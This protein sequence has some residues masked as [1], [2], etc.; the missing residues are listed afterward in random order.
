[1][2]SVNAG[3]NAWMLAATVLGLLMTAPGLALFYGGLVRRKN[4]LGTMMQSFA[5]MAVISVVWAVLGYSLGFAAGGPLL[6]GLGHVF[7]RGVGASPDADYAPTVPHQTFMMFQLVFAIITPA[8]ITGAVAERARFRSIVL[9]AILWSLGVYAPLAH[10]V[11]AKGGL[12]SAAYGGRLPC[13]DFA[14]GTVVHVSSGVSALVAALYLGRRQGYPR[15][16]MPPHS[17]VLSFAGACLLWV[18]WLALN[19]G[20]AMGASGLATSAL[21][22][23]HLAAAAGSLGWGVTEWLRFGKPSALGAITGAVAGL[24][25]ISPAAGFVGPMTALL[26]GALAGVACHVMVA[27]VKMRF[28]YDDS[29]DVFGVHGAAG[30]LG[31][32]LT[33]VFATRAVNPVFVDAAGTALPVGLVDGNPGQVAR[34]LGAVAVAWALSGVGSYLM[35]KVVDLVAGLRVSEEQETV[36]LDLTQHGEDGYNLET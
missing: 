31:T 4:V 29:L 12:L 17:V 33:G 3:D 9:F 18:G 22:A 34:Q 8:L 30:T 19:A 20:R 35:L 25:G 1:M 32:L 6:G 15:Q 2:T 24:V 7:L 26:I 14:G 10:M 11:W 23:T 21:V 13:L 27:Y 16:P 28:G 36:G 5:L